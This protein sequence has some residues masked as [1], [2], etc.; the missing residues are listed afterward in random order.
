MHTFTATVVSTKKTIVGI[1]LWAVCCCLEM[2][3][4]WPPPATSPRPPAQ[5]S[6]RWSLPQVLQV[7]TMQSLCDG[8]LDRALGRRLSDHCSAQQTGTA[9]HLFEVHSFLPDGWM[10]SVHSAAFVNSLS[11]EMLGFGCVA[12]VFVFCFL[13]QSGFIWILRPP[14]CQPDVRGGLVPLT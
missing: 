10:F 14:L 1:L 8:T 13:K 11:S 3:Q 7:Q 4:R 12:Q 2:P 9:H 5:L 6:Q